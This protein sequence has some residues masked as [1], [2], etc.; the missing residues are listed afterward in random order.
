MIL[1]KELHDKVGLSV[2][3]CCINMYV[4]VCICMYVGMYICMYVCMY[5]WLPHGNIRRYR[6]AGN[7][8]IDKSKAY[9]L[10][11]SKLTT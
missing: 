9:E 3:V 7:K 8:R 6:I 10:Y 1:F 5:F 2:C 4:Y 11:N